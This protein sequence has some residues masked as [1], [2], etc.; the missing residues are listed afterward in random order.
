MRKGPAWGKRRLRDVEQRILPL[1]EGAKEQ[2]K[3]GTRRISLTPREEIIKTGFI[4]WRLTESALKNE[5]ESYEKQASQS[6]KKDEEKKREIPLLMKKKTGRCKSAL[7]PK[8][9]GDLQVILVKGRRKLKTS[10]RSYPRQKKGG[11]LKRVSE[12]G[13]Q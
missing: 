2:Q 4:K 10:P 9:Q 3:L 6:S 8:T 12:P 1:C 7:A 5:V 13:L 11:T